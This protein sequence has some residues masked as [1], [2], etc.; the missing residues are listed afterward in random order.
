MSKVIKI[1]VIGCGHWGPNH[2]RI[3]SSLRESKVMTV[4]DLNQDRLDY[5]KLN[6]PK[7]NVTKESEKIFTN[8]EIDAVIVSTPAKTHYEI[9]KK[10]LL[11]NKHVLCEKPLAI[12]SRDTIELENIANE[13]NL[14]LMTGHI[15]LFNNGINVLKDYIC[16][17][18]L[19]NIH[20][21]TAIRTNFGPIRNDVNVVF[22]LGT[23]DISIFNYL[24][25][26][27]PFEVSANGISKFDQELEDFSFITL[28]YP[29]DIIANIHISWIVRNK[30]RQ[31]T[32]VGDD[33]TVLWD[34]LSNLGPIKIYDSG[35]KK[36]SYY[37]S[38]GD[39]QLLSRQGDILIPKVKIQEPLENEAIHFLKVISGLET[40]YSGGKFSTQILKVIEAINESMQNRGMP[41]KLD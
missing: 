26:C 15:F 32:I 2:I 1:G 4:A 41:I 31:I 36:E 35:N 18:V 24:L 9:V 14:V 33:K 5:V 37:D 19:G 8:D 11:A 16:N 38:Y 39:F 29:N 40:N 30:I 6:R 7:I 12:C 21:L 22:D 27:Q 25:D 13:R 10:A 23:H 28:R 17:N 34:D 3:F 20:H